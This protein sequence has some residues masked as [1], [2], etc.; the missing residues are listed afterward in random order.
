MHTLSNVRRDL[1]EFVQSFFAQGRVW[2]AENSQRIFRWDPERDKTGIIIADSAITDSD[3]LNK[4]PAIVVNRGIIQPDNLG[5]IGAGLDKYDWNTQKSGH[6]EIFNV[7]ITFHSLSSNDEEA[8]VLGQLVWF[9]LWFHRGLLLKQYHYRKIDFGGIGSPRILKTEGGTSSPRI[10]D[11]PVQVT[12]H[13]HVTYYY[14]LRGP[15]DQE[16]ERITVP[17]I[18]EIVVGDG[19][20]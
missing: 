1:L 14:Q 9:L 19:I 18:R 2:G 15:D 3:Q 13:F 10:W 5:G 11:V 17:L 20:T 6:V 7:P 16:I 4:T 8:E 12:V